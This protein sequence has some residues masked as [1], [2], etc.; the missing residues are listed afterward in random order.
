MSKKFVNEFERFSSSNVSFFAFNYI[1][2]CLSDCWDSRYEASLML[3]S[4]E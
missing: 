2:K 3:T 1:V 4:K